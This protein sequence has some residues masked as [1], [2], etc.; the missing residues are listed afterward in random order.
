[1]IPVIYPTSDTATIL[2]ICSKW[3]PDIN[4]DVIGHMEEDDKVI[5]PKVGNGVGKIEGSNTS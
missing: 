3:T 4:A 5:Y 2:H 1:M